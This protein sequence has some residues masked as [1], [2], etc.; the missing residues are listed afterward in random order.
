MIISLNWLKKLTDITSSVDELSTL[1]GERLV[2]IEGIEYTGDKY[3]DVIIVRVVEASNIEGSDHLHLTKIDDGGVVPDVERDERGLVQV[4]CGAPNVRADMLAAWL[5]PRSTVPETFGSKEPFVLGARQLQGHTSNGMLASAKELDLYD[6]H[7]GIVDIEADVAPGTYFAEFCEL[8]DALLDIENK[9]LTHRPDAFGMV[10]FA[11]EVAGIQG[12]RFTTPAWLQDLEPHIEND[13][14]VETPTITIHDPALSERFEALVIADI[15][16]NAHRPLGMQTLLSRSGM[17]PINA[18]VDVTNYLMLLTGQPLH[19]YDYDK[20]V[21]IAGGKADIH[22]RAGRDG[23]TLKLLDGKIIELSEDDIVI[24]AGSTPVGLAGAMGGADTEIDGTTKRILL[25]SATFN[26][27]KLRNMQM[28]YGIFSEAITRMTKGVPAPLGAPVL[29]EAARMISELSYGKVVSAVADAYPGKTDAPVI[30]LPLGKI[31]ETLGTQF[32]AEDVTDILQ[33]VGFGVEVEELHFHVTVPYWRTDIHIPEDIIEEVGRLAGFDTITLTVPTRSFTAVRPDS[34]DTLRSHLRS[35]LVRAGANE[36]LTYSFIHS[37]TMK[38]AG[39]NPEQA[40]RITN[41]ISPD[42]QYYR[43]SLTPSLLTHIHPNIKAGYDHFA[44]FELNKFH[45]KLT[46]ETEEGV[47]KELDELALVVASSRKG[48]GAAFYEAKGYLEFIATALGLQFEYEP[49]EETS[50]YPVTQPFEYRRAARVWDKHTHERIGVVGEFKKSVQKAFKLPEHTAG[51]EIAPRALQ[52]LTDALEPAYQ[53]L[54]KYP[55]TER[56]VCFQVPQTT[57]YQTVAEAVKHGL[58]SDLLTTVEP[59]D[60]YQAEKSD[61]KNV[62]VRISL[63]SYEK[64]LTGEDV[65][66]AIDA[67]IKHV[68]E[69]LGATLV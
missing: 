54:S 64:T 6:D 30:E 29:A 35:S 14:S 69:K 25:E 23:E 10:G 33:N 27:Y 15:D 62:T 65:S 41:S 2:E 56:D 4:V 40:Y 66:Q 63:V 32:A 20:L 45:T 36:V 3:K 61:T 5:P 50:D 19:A 57:S 34:F 42:L 21:E 37:D 55:G 46:G 16:V 17:R 1:I 68:T 43:Q 52:K 8:D 11:R 28:R 59:L 31:N 48:Q 44:L 12:K 67:M 24:A 49:L 53:A 26:L 13:G 60:L 7:M 58:E 22:V 51:F 18:V 9:S 39:Q 38:K 47:P